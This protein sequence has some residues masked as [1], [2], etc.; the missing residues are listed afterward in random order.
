MSYNN[1]DGI[2]IYDGE[3]KDGMKSGRGIMTS[4]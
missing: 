3:F 2:I 4:P 1:Q